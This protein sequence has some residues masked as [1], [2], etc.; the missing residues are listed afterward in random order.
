MLIHSSDLLG[1]PVVTEGGTALGKVSGFELDIDA[2][3]IRAYEVRRSIVGKK[4][5]VNRA[6][7][8]AITKEKMIVKD[9]VVS[10]TVMHADMRKNLS[11]GGVV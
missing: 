8:V 10:Y 3:F 2:H 4:L 5:L 11:Y 6:Q 9:E 7:V 1:L